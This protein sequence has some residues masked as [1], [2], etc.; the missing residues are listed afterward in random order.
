[1]YIQASHQEFVKGICI[2]EIENVQACSVQ[3][4]HY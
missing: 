4:N 1:M 2:K 3:D